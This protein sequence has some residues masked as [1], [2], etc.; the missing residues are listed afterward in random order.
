MNLTQI[1]A[2][3][4]WPTSAGKTFISFYAMSRILKESDDGVLVYV[5]PTKA[6]VNQIATEIHARFRKAYPTAEKTVW[7]IHTRD[8]RVHDPMQCQILVTAP[9]LLQ[10]VRI[11]D[12]CLYGIRH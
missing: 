9:H 1:T 2:F 7:A 8:I 4:S 3:L 5:A 12:F 10:I 6:L 11:S